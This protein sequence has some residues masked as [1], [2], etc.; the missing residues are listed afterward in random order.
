MILIKR[1]HRFVEANVVKAL[2]LR[3]ARHPRCIVG[4]PFRMFREK[5]FNKISEFTYPIYVIAFE[6]ASESTYS[7]SARKI[8]LELLGT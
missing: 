6:K 7:R 8:S 2:L 5:A 4:D 1:R 3:S